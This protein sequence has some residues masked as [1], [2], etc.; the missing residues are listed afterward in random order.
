[1]RTA[2]ELYKFVVNNNYG[3]GISNKW[4]MRHFEV[5]EERLRDGENVLFAFVGSNVGDLNMVGNFAYVITNERILMGQK[6]TFGQKTKS[7]LLE[8]LNDV[9]FKKDFNY[10]T[11]MFDT[12][13]DKLIIRNNRKVN[14]DMEFI[15]Q[16]IIFKLKENK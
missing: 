5:V 8:Q 15:I 12:I 3:K 6:K 4:I 14:P 7:V 13:K 1:M 10:F 2:E 16:D 9:T 11:I